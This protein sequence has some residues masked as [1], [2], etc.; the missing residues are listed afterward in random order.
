METE[1]SGGVPVSKGSLNPHGRFVF[2]DAVFAPTPPVTATPSGT[3][4][5][6][7]AVVWRRVRPPS[8]QDLPSVVDMEADD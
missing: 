7:C 1:A 6:S 3:S 4:G 5:A 8:I 2:S